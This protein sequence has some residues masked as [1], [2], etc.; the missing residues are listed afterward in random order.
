[1]RYFEFV[2]LCSL[3]VVVVCPCGVAGAQSDQAGIGLAPP[4][5]ANHNSRGAA[6]R[7]SDDRTLEVAPR[8]GPVE[9]LPES[10]GPPPRDAES[11]PG[12]SALEEPAEPVPPEI[13]GNRGTHQRPYLG[14][15]VT[16][17]LARFHGQETRGLQIVGVDQGSPAERAGLKAST[18]MTAVGATGETAGY[19][20]GPVG[21]LMNPLLARAG[22]LGEGGDMVVA[23]DDRRV[24][25]AD[26]LN[27]AVARLQPGETV[28]LTV[29]RIAR[30]G[31]PRT[32]KVAVV[33]GAAHGSY[34]G[35]SSAA[36]EYG[37]SPKPK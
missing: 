21:L 4:A 10:V 3:T 35:S 15:S 20:L 23:V 6:A 19:L 34:L 22:Q 11:S 14:I 13:S 28:W 7:D 9:P 18:S 2:A 33:L 32:N 30:D 27:D 25:S 5:G 31:K 37:R 1:M 16:P 29:L 24:S 26:E 12:I 36:V 8:I 17:A